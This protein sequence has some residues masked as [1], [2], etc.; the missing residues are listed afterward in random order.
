MQRVS[1]NSIITLLSQC[2]TLHVSRVFTIESVQWPFD[3]ARLVVFVARLGGRSSPVF[4]Y[5]FFVDVW[6]RESAGYFGISLSY[7]CGNNSRYSSEVALLSTSRFNAPAVGGRMLDRLSR[8][9]DRTGMRTGS[10]MRSEKWLDGLSRIKY[11]ENSKEEE[12]ALPPW[13]EAGLVF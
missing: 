12:F 7:Q 13:L 9:L 4:L 10:F 1:Y 3:V 8:S 11:Q 2:K 5:T 6:F